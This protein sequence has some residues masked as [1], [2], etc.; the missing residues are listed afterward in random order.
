[1]FLLTYLPLGLYCFTSSAENSSSSG[2]TSQYDL[3]E[4]ILLGLSTWVLVRDALGFGS[5]WI[6]LEAIPTHINPLKKYFALEKLW[7]FRLVGVLVVFPPLKALRIRISGLVNNWDSCRQQVQ[8]SPTFW[9]LW[10]RAEK[11]AFMNNTKLKQSNSLQLLDGEMWLVSF[12]NGPRGSPRSYKTISKVL[13]DKYSHC[14][15]VNMSLNYSAK[16]FR[17]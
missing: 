17:I 3:F 15:F 6:S 2:S 14:S 16:L 7:V 12:D 11:V 8:I 5:V 9:V 10:S 1:M 4:Q 13:I